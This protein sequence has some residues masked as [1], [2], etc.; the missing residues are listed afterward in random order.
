[1][2]ALTFQ[3]QKPDCILVLQGNK[4]CVEFF[5]FF[6]ESVVI[7][8][9]GAA[10]DLLEIGI[11]PNVVIGD[12]DSFDVSR[13][14]DE[15]C[16]VIIDKNQENNDFEKALLYSLDKGYSHI[17]IW[18]MHGGDFEHTL[19]NTSVLW[20]YTGDFNQISIADSLHRVA[21]PVYVDMVCSEL[22]PDEVV[23]L[24]P[25]PHARLTTKGFHWE[26]NNEVLELSVREGARNRSVS[27]TISISV[28]EGRFLFFCNTRFPK[29]PIFTNILSSSYND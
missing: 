2:K 5:S 25:F 26:L 16:L 21:V 9:D 19:N 7:A 12:M 8:A 18:G 23:S 28:H 20:K 14:K 24:I 27:S 4:P 29:T 17:M 6:P 3:H 22:Y 15:S 10:S 11:K 1:M 13:V